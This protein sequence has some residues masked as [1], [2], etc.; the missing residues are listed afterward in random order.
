[1]HNLE[2]DEL[3]PPA[4]RPPF[5]CNTSAHLLRIGRERA[6]N[7]SEL[8]QGLRTCAENSIFEHTFRTLQEHHFIRKGSSND[9]A[10]RTLTACHEPGCGSS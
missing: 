10:H 7:L 4:E 5:H 3:P 9:F 2:T 1:M 6:T 8:I